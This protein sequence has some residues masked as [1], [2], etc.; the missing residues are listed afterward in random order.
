MGNII[1]NEIDSTLDYNIN[2][3]NKNLLT[4]YIYDWSINNYTTTN[5]P[6]DLMLNKDVLKKRAC[7]IYNSGGSVDIDLP[8]YNE[9]YDD[10]IYTTGPIIPEIPSTSPP[11]SNTPTSPPVLNT[12]IN[13][14][15]KNLIENNTNIIN[16]KSVRIPVFPGIPTDKDCSN[17]ITKPGEGSFFNMDMVTGANESCQNF[18]PRFCSA[19]KDMRNL[20]I[21]PNDNTLTEDVKIYGPNI[22]L[23]GVVDSTKIGVYRN[24]FSDCDCQ[25]CSFMLYPEKYAMFDPNTGKKTLGIDR[26]QVAQM[27][28]PFCIDAMDHGKAYIPF[29][30]PK[31]PICINYASFD[32]TQMKDDAAVNLKQN[33]T[34][35]QSTS[36]VSGDNKS[37]NLNNSTS[38]TISQNTNLSTPNP[39][40]N[41][42]T[43]SPSSNPLTSSPSVNLSSNL[44]NTNLS[45]NLS[46]T[47][48][49]SNLSSNLSNTNP[50]LNPLNTNPSSN[51]S[52]TNPS[53]NPSNTNPSLNSPN[54]NLLSS[55]FIN[56]IVFFLGLLFI[57][58]LFISMGS[59]ILYKNINK[60]NKYK[61][62]H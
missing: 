50:S 53:L 59:Y 9:N 30:E 38:S 15:P 33:C 3:P 45:S 6:E 16:S 1:S 52:T 24:S 26:I 48:P 57:I 32:N 28:D 58:V 27:K 47:N 61:N 8:V 51:P 62:Y 12:L 10:N 55:S 37:L 39:S 60:K 18:Y 31:V 7:C 34:I 23:P 41:S 2:D 54:T 29:V 22:N 56:N 42:S 13:L 35:N 19:V 21:I 46:N 14:G 4:K 40:L 44:S 11:I 49:S 5:D 17:L 43:P 25:N 36:T 20:N